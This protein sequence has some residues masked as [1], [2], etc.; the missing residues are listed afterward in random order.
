MTELCPPDQGTSPTWS[1]T[2]ASRWPRGFAG[3]VVVSL[4]V[5]CSISALS[6][7]PSRTTKAEIQN[8]ISKAITAPSE[9]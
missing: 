8:H 7:A 2:Y 1:A 6:S 5:W 4:R 3:P 9:P